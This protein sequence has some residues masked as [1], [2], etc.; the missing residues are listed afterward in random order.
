MS[1]AKTIGDRIYGK[2]LIKEKVLIELLNSQPLLRL[3]KIS[4]FGVPDKY[5]I[6]KNYSRFEHSVGVMILLRKLGASVEE[7]VAG[8]IHDVS[9]FTFSHVADWVLGKGQEGNEDLQDKLFKKFIKG[10]EIAKILK[11]HGFAIKRILNEENFPLLEKKIPDICADR[12]D[13][14]LR[15]FNKAQ[16]KFCLKGIANHDGE[17]VFTDQKIAL[18]FSRNFLNLQI[19]HWG[20]Y[21]AVARYQLFSKA[22]KYA[23][24]KGVIVEADFYKEEPEIIKKLES[25]KV[26]EI[27]ELLERLKTKKLKQKTKHLGKKVVKKFRYVDPKVLC[28]GKVTRLSNL[29]PG[30]KKEIEK[31]RKINARGIYI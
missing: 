14:A 6:K 11:R 8:L 26:K 24:D 9:H 4:Q 13:Y 28:K 5:Y 31:H 12:V 10:G 22:L 3:K 27:N 29:V 25:S 15:E 18:L 16:A 21:E 17:I 30:F 7:Q 2:F 23:L 1:K 20:V 19:N